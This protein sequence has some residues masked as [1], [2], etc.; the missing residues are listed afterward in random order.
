MAVSYRINN[1]NIR[2]QQLVIESLFKYL[3]EDNRAEDL[4][5]DSIT[6]YAYTFPF[7][8]QNEV[9]LQL[10]GYGFTKDLS[11]GIAHRSK[12]VELIGNLNLFCEKLRKDGIANEPIE[13]IYSETAAC[14]VRSYD[15]DGAEAILKNGLEIL[16]ASVE[17]KTQLQTISTSKNDLQKFM[18]N[19]YTQVSAS[20]VI[21]P[22]AYKDDEV[23][24]SV[25]KYVNKCWNVDFYKKDGKT[26]ETKVEQLKFI[27]QANSKMKFKTG[28]EEHWG[29]WK[30]IASG[31]TL[32]LKSNEDQQQL[33]ILIYEA[34]ATQ[35]RGILSPYKNENKK[36]EFNVCEK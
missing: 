12:V 36:I 10:L 17:L 11:N 25:K 3:E 16:P 29:T 6:N 5:L 13:T 31:P 34:S 7:L 18:K 4:P 1:E 15:Y 21:K 14:L 9:Y 24:A 35:M 2:T 23:Y 30:L 22:P 26:R 19:S 8:L 27:F 28:T 32:T 33:T 20:Q